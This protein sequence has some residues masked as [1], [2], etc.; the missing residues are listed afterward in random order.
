MN[1]TENRCVN[2][3]MVSSFCIGIH[4]N[5]LSLLYIVRVDSEMRSTFITLCDK[6]TEDNVI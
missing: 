3:E 4:R 5:Y 6:I 2:A 1:P